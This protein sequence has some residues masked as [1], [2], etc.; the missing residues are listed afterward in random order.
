MKVPAS[1]VVVLVSTTAYNSAGQIFSVFTP[2]GIENRIEYDNQGRAT[3]VVENYTDGIPDGAANRTTQYTYN[4]DGA[5]ELL[6]V[7]NSTTG[8]QVTRWEY[9]S[10]LAQS[11]VASSMLLRAKIFADS[12]E[13]V[14]PSSVAVPSDR[15]EYTYNRLGQITSS[16]DQNG[17]IHDYEYDARGRLVVD[18]VPALG[19]GLDGTVRRISTTYDNLGHIASV[20]SYDVPDDGT[21]VNQVVKTYDPFGQLAEDAQAHTGAVEEGTPTVTYEYE[22]SGV[23]TIPPTPVRV[24]ARPTNIIYPDGRKIELGYGEIGSIDDLLS[25]VATVTDVTTSSPWEVATYSYMGADTSVISAYAEPEVELTYIKQGS[26]PD[27]PAGDPYAGL[28]RFGRIIDHRW[29]KSGA[30]IERIQYGYNLG[31]LRQWRLDTLAHSEDKDQDNYYNYDGLGQVIARDQGQLAND[32]TGVDGVPSREEDWVYDPS[33]NWDN[34]R[35][36]VDGTT[37]VNQNRTHTKVNEIQTFDGS[38]IPVVFDR[39]GNMTRMP[40]ALAGTSYYE[41]IWDAWNRLVRVKTPGGSGGYGSYSGMSLDVKYAYDGQ[42][43][44]TTTEVVT[45]QDPG[46]THYYYNAAWKCIEQRLNDTDV[47]YKQFVFGARGRNDLVFRDQFE[48]ALVDRLYALCDNMGSKVAL[49]GSDGLV[50]ERYAFTAFGD[51]EEIMAADY[52]PRSASLIGWETFFHG[53]V[54]DSETGWYNYGYRYY[55]PQLGR[56]PSRDPIGEE[57]GI[58][59]YGFVGNNG[60]NGK[61]QLGLFGPFGLIVGAGAD[62]AIQVS[63]NYACGKSGSEAWSDVDLSSIIISGVVGGLGAPGVAGTGWKVFKKSKEAYKIAKKIQKSNQVGK[64]ASSVRAA[65]ILRRYEDKLKKLSTIGDEVQYAVGVAAG[66]VAVKKTLNAI[67]NK[68]ER[69]ISEALGEEDCCGTYVV[70]I[71]MDSTIYTEPV[72][73]ASIYPPRNPFEYDAYDFEVIHEFPTEITPPINFPPP[74]FR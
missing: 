58:Y 31:G 44:R 52:T 8:A 28:D 19:S 40:K 15:I 64:C 5:L 69:G 26:E 59:L 18:R 43:R 70:T 61:D 73:P 14:N 55:L 13:A 51:L 68:I 10:N 38:G 49:T 67:T 16:T 45:G 20:T 46:T 57:G 2:M 47:A 11:G 32:R 53:E 25:R 24:T 65:K 41:A 4:A 33:G 1:S 3:K 30:D 63:L 37:A 27:G 72:F 6:K 54:R 36:K 62:Y 22:L 56:W 60:I 17:T 29:I 35:R 12:D 71:R 23:E 21:V 66:V 74:P 39:A 50:I 7:Q 9:G 34:Y 42:T 48:G